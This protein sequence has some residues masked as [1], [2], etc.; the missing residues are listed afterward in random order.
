[1]PCG[2]C[3]SPSLLDVVLGWVLWWGFAHSLEHLWIARPRR[4]LALAN[5][6]DLEPP[7]VAV[8]EE[9]LHLGADGEERLAHLGPLDASGLAAALQVGEELIAHRRVDRKSTRLNSSHA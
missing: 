7:I 2:P 9:E 4:L 8:V 1:M 5:Q 3:G 6:L